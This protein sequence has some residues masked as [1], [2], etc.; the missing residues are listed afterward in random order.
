M[1]KIVV[2][3]NCLHLNLIVSNIVFIVS[4]KEMIENN[5]KENKKLAIGVEVPI[6]PMKKFHVKAHISAENKYVKK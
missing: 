6:I 3:K 5:C 2:D 1:I 4:N